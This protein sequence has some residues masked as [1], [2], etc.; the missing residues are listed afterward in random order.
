[1]IEAFNAGTVLFGRERIFVGYAGILANAPNGL[2]GCQLSGQK[3]L[4]GSP[5]DKRSLVLKEQASQSA[6][7]IVSPLRHEII[8]GSTE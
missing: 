2:L 6:K 4:D 1:M 7:V 3:L 5:D 8:V